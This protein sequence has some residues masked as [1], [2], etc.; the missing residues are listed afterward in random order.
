MQGNDKRGEPTRRGAS[1]TLYVLAIAAVALLFVL[2]VVLFRMGRSTS[3]TA[4]KPT[5]GAGSSTAGGEDTKELFFY[6]AAGVRPPVERIAAEYQ[7]EYGIV[8]RI[9]YGGSQTLLSQIDVSRSGDLYL[10]ADDSYI[11]LARARGL[12]EERI[13][14]G[15]QRPVIAVKK[16]NPKG[17]HGV[18]DLLRPDV[19]VALG[20]PDQ[21]AIGRITRKVL[22]KSGHWDALKEQVTKTGVFLPTVPEVANNVKLG[23]ADAGIVWD[24]TLAIYPELEAV[25][26]PELDVGKSAIIVAVLSSSKDPTRALHF[27]RYLT[28]KDKGLAVFS[29]MGFETVE[30]DKWA[31]VPEIVF[32]AGS[33]N[34]R[35]VEPIV[36]EFEKR[37]G[38]RIN[39]VYNGC[40]I[41]T[42]QMRTIKEQ[43]QGLGFPDAYMACDVYYLNTVR[44]WFQEDVEVSDTE[45]VIAV[46][47]G[48][49]KGIR[50]LKDLTKPG[51]RVSVGQPDQCTIGV[52]T[53]EL[54]K[55][56]GL[57]DQVMKNVVTQTASSAM[58]VPTVVTGS[59]DATL[60]YLTD[61]LAEKDRVDVIRIPSEA[62]KA[63]QPFAIAKSS[64]HK[65]L[66]RRLFEAIARSRDKFEA[67][68]FHFRLEGPRPTKISTE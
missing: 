40:G 23:A 60:A 57:Y 36:K 59:V 45:I 41:L 30:G 8:V 3:P 58:L 52:L 27:A 35:S 9:Q 22:Q 50:S 18:E 61:T 32:Y 42:A 5:S 67:A 65:W 19:K 16:G 6:C 24:A 53:R 56:E 48:N 12:V 33:V 43:R 15:Y 31:D 28:A 64:E 7:K 10:A 26:T 11:K 20:N 39:T 55:K 21:A 54:L 4:T 13:P 68:G 38:I 37:E 47:K 66:V 62:A 25:R 34:R 51:I 2:G 17:I 1:N 49:P 63:I 29:E 14:I 46:P 44:D